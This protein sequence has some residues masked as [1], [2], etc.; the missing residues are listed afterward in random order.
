M[1][2]SEKGVE[3]IKHFE[4]LRLQAYQ[5]A[6]HVWTLGYGH[7]AGVQPGDTV[8]AEQADA[9]LQQDI[10]RSE[11]YVDQYVDVLLT[12]SQ[13]DALVSFTFNLGPVALQGSTLLKKLNAGDYSGAAAEFLLWV[14][15][16]GEKLPGLVRRRQS[17]KALFDT[18]A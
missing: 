11:R 9:L 16:G 14:N 15:A 5:C 6:A 4:G 10:A 1:N 7:T 3:L 17:E 12:Q 8:T 2:T 13:F 18:P